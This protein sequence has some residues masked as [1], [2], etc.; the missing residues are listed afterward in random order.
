MAKT[1]TAESFFD[2]KEFREEAIAR[3]EVLDKVKQLVLI[4]ELECMTIKQLADYYEVDVDTI[5]RQYQRNQD[6]FDS[7]GACTKSLSD[8]KILNRT[9]CS[10]KNFTQLNGRMVIT[11]N[12][13]TELIIPNRGIKCFPKRAILRMGM[14]LRDS[15]IAA[16]VRTQIL[17]GYEKLTPEQR[18]DE[19][20]KEEDLVGSIIKSALKGETQNVLTTFTDYIGFK[21]RYIAKIEKNNAELTQENARISEQKEK[22]E[23]INKDLTTENHVLAADIL[24]WTDRASANRLIRVLAGSLNRGFADTFNLVYHE[25]YYK[26]SISLKTRAG[27]AKKKSLPLISFI[28][29]NEW[30]YLYKVV[31]AICNNKGINL[32][33]LFKKA[34][35]DVSTLDLN[36]KAGAV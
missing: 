23:E 27:I 32:T 12:N 3:I 35:I 21:N 28:K 33:S 18:T 5:K 19:I 2:D 6:E 24:K 15:K 11:F 14:L 26:Y 34:K 10:V 9:S 13:G 4:P 25:L 31:A 29:D 8:F 36:N 30:I 20:D 22:V 16:E 17:N 7:D 1:I